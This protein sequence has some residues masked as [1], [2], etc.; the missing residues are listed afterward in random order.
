M[1]YL[2]VL[3]IYVLDV[4][5]WEF[6]LGRWV[7]FNGDRLLSDRDGIFDYSITRPK[8]LALATL[9]GLLT[10]TFLFVLFHNWR[11]IAVSWIVSLCH[12]EIKILNM[13]HWSRMFRKSVCAK[14]KC[15][16]AKLSLHVQIKRPSRMQPVKTWIGVVNSITI[17]FP[18]L[19]SRGLLATTALTTKYDLE[20]LSNNSKREPGGR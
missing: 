2:D 12:A 13:M 11:Y 15:S 9:P 10:A 4:R 6:R 8:H 18:H 16:N 14:I 19:H 5:A 1:F 7:R 20:M 17:A 3:L